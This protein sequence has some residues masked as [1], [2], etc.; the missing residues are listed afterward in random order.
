MRGAGVNITNNN[1]G[2][3]IIALQ[4]SA[5][6]DIISGSGTDEVGGYTIEGHIS[7]DTLANF[8]KR[9]ATQY[10]GWKKGNAIFGTCGVGLYSD[11]T[12]VIWK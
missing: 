2:L 10:D 8:T 6:D 9:Y 1:S 5:G 11:G 4:N 3:M 7:V 12:I